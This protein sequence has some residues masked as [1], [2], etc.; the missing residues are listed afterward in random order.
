M[1]HPEE[2]SGRPRTCLGPPL[3]RPL[4]IARRPSA[5]FTASYRRPPS[6]RKAGLVE[7]VSINKLETTHYQGP[8]QAINSELHAVDDEWFVAGFGDRFEPI[9][10]FTGRQPCP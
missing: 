6:G 8:S 7:M 10:N 3:V 1:W 9:R 5:G 4:I 2:A